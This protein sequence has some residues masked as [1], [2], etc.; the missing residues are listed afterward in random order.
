[1]N[2]DVQPIPPGYHTI[3]PYI[4]VKDAHKAID[5]YQRALGAELLFKMDAPGGKIG[6]S[7]LKIGDS[8]IMMADEHPDIGAVAPEGKTRSFSLMVYVPDVDRVFNQAIAAGAKVI[9][10]L[11]NKFYGDRMGTIEDPFGH[12]WH[13][14]MTVENVSPEEMEIRAKKA[15]GLS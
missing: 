2:T 6:H 5:F 8:R 4:I 7:E 15:Y 9:N 14:G 10:P 11:E 3:T 12:Q 1:M 13:L